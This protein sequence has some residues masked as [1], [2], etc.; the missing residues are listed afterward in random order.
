MIQGKQQ[1]PQKATQMEFLF[2][3]KDLF[4]RYQATST[5][6]YTFWYLERY[7]IDAI[8]LSFM[9]LIL[10]FYTC[11]MCLFGRFVW[12]VLYIFSLSYIQKWIF[13]NEYEKQKAK[14]PIQTE[15]NCQNE[16]ILIIFPYHSLHFWKISGYTSD[17]C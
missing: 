13:S 2:L 4:S 15:E 17:W 1:I 11:K 5:V 14:H 10:L 12:I 8:T 16:W 3:Q 9:L 6:R 7:C